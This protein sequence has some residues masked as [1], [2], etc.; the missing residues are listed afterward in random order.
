MSFVSRVLFAAVLVGSGLL[1]PVDSRAQ[2]PPARAEESLKSELAELQKLLSEETKRRETAS[3]ETGRSIDSQSLADAAVF[4]KAGEW[5]LR[6]QEFY[7]P[8]YVEQTRQALKLGKE[9]IQNLSEDKKPWQNRVGSTVLGY[10]SKVDGSVQPYALTL[11]EGVDPKSGTRWP[12]YVVLHGRQANMNEVNFITRHEDKP[13]PEGQTWIQ[14]DVFGRTNNAY[15]FAGET[16][17]F[18]AIA[19]VRQRYRIDDKRITLWGFSMGGAGAWH[20][21]VHHPSQWASVGTG[22]GFVDFYKYQKRKD[23]LPEHQDKTLKIYDAVEYALNAANVPI[24]TYGGELDP[25][26]AAGTTMVAAAEKEGVQIPLLVGKGMGHAFDP[27]SK[28]QFLAFLAEHNKKGRPSYPG[29]KKVRFITHTLKYNTCEWVT[30]SEMN[31]P[32]Q[33]AIVEGEVTDDGVLK[34]STKNVAVLAISRDVAQDIELD[35][36][37]LPLQSAAEGL[38]PDV[39]YDKDERGWIVLDYN[40]SRSHMANSGPNKRHN[41]QGPI[42]DAFMQ[43]FICIQGTGTP[44]VEAQNDWAHWTLAR[45]EREFDKWMRGKIP[46]I[47]DEELTEEILQDKNLIL[48]GDP[49]S[50][51]VL[52]Q[53]LPK[54]PIEWTKDS[55]QVAGKTWDPKTHGLSMIYPN[56]LNPHRYVVINS[57]HTFHEKDFQASNAWL[58]PR[59]GDIAVQRFEKSAEGGYEETVEW[60]EIFHSGWLLPPEA[61]K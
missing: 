17:V 51:K 20:L 3:E 61:T 14:L 2:K 34:V 13:L 44:W 28:E 5:I 42:D 9:R 15:R 55:I 25:Q 24:I 38:L 6:H 35:G 16:D 40:A 11:P 22:A 49:G 21:G 7:R 26:L 56:P 53:I 52:A 37:K 43:P 27:A 54:L 32:Y 36:D 48:F 19:D 46:I 33:P 12:L 58:F 18:E 30:I 45:F 50:N 29:A 31:F 10:V 8:N 39:Y 59:L 23:K 4:A 57:G 47:T 60:A 1:L 41:L